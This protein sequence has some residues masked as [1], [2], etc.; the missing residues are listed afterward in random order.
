M[1]FFLDK[2]FHKINFVLKY[3]R[4]AFLFLQ[5]LKGKINKKSS[6]HSAN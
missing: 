6:T 1:I 2:I 5:R 3:K 4:F